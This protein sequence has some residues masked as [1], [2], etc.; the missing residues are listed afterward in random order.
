MEYLTAFSDFMKTLFTDGGIIVWLLLAMLIWGLYIIVIKSRQL[1]HDRLINPQVI[2]HI[3]RLL[4]DKRLPE[5]TAY[6]KQNSSPITRII[7]AGIVNFDRSEGELKEIL[8]ETGRQEIPGIRHHLSTLGTIAGLAPL[9]GLLGTVVGMIQVFATLSEGSG[10][11]AND[12]ASG[13]SKALTTTACG[14]AVTMPTMAYYNS[15]NNRATNLIIEM[16]KVSLHMAAILSRA[17]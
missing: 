7:L 8:E 14:L 3:E 16:E 2:Q 13:I 10:I 5:A 11:N 17:R 15:L 12:L 6:C 4:L 9:L 1:H